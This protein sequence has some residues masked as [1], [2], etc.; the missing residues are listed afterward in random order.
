[1]K[2]LPK[3]R[4]VELEGPHFLPGFALCVQAKNETMPPSPWAC[5]ALNRVVRADPHLKVMSAL[6]GRH[7]VHRMAGE[8]RA[9]A[10]RVGRRHGKI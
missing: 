8:G 3:A 6:D 9:P 7:P 10:S 2:S 5:S 1:V 4:L